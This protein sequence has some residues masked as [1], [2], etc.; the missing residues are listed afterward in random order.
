MA[1]EIAETF[2]LNQ[3][4]ILPVKLDK[5]PTPPHMEPYNYVELYKP[6]GYGK[7]LRAIE[8]GRNER[9]LFSGAEKASHQ[10]LRWLDSHTKNLNIS[11]HGLSFTYEGTKLG[12]MFDVHAD[13]M[14]V[15]CSIK[16]EDSLDEQLGRRLLEAN[17][18]D[19]KEC[20]YAIEDDNIYCT[21]LH[22]LSEL[23]ECQ[24]L[25]ALE[26]CKQLQDRFGEDFKTQRG[27]IVMYSKC[28]S[29]NAT[30]ENLSAWIRINY[31]TAV[32]QESGYKLM[33]R[34]VAMQLEKKPRNLFLVR[35]DIGK[36]FGQSN[37]REMLEANA[38]S[39]LE[40]RYALNRN[41]PTSVFWHL[42][43][44]MSEKLLVSAV[45]QTFH[46]VTNYG[47]TYSSSEWS[48]RGKMDLQ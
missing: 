24:F 46:L 14:R 27:D 35:A 8:K 37:I 5:C 2:P 41:M 38:H 6:G 21:F 32:E 33:I 1:L 11:A 39:A 20:R 31:P 43:S 48:F 47:T 10:L 44:E 13:R 45:T 26:G 17:Q 34:D 9:N 28:H 30:W 42:L 25:Q 3:I 7:L 18:I 29:S 22:P 12:C 40:P 36:P 23:T 19:T 16:G 4:F 15:F